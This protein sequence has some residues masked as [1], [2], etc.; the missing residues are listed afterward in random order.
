MAFLVAA[1]GM[2]FL[3]LPPALCVTLGAIGIGV[4]FIAQS[5]ELR[6]TGLTADAVDHYAQTIGLSCFIVGYF[7][8][9]TFWV[10]LA[11]II[12]GLCAVLV[13]FGAQIA[14]KWAESK[15]LWRRFKRRRAKAKRR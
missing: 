9:E 4:C 15:D 3:E 7:F 11:C 6:E 1:M 10:L 8:F 2:L 12:V 5:L 14:G 13:S